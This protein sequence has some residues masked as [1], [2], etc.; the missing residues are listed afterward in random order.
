MGHL[1]PKGFRFLTQKRHTPF[2]LNTIVNKKEIVVLDWKVFIC[3][4]ATNPHF[5]FKSFLIMILNT[6]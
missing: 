1:A 5:D 2:I 6:V 4:V 3:G